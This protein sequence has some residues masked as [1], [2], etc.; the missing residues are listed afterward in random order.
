MNIPRLKK[1]SHLNVLTE[2]VSK[3]EEGTWATNKEAK[4]ILE[5]AEKEIKDVTQAIGSQLNVIAGGLVSTRTSGIPSISVPTWMFGA[6][7]AS[8]LSVVISAVL[9]SVIG[10]IIALCGTFFFIN[11][12]NDNATMAS[13][14]YDKVI[15]KLSAKNIIETSIGSEIEKII[16]N[17]FDVMVPEQIKTICDRLGGEYDSIDGKRERIVRLNRQV[18]IIEQK[19]EEFRKVYSQYDTT[20][21]D[22]KAF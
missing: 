16:H 2:V 14:T 7:L 6:V 10:P 18:D 20:N 9:G 11:L 12:I 3:I 4:E 19:M 17:I 5:E 22:K 13:N 8:Q 21:I 1:D 15:A